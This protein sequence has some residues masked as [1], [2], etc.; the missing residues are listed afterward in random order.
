MEEQAQEY[1][2]ETQCGFFCEPIELKIVQGKNVYHGY[3]DAPKEFATVYT[4]KGAAITAISKFEIQKNVIGIVPIHA[5][6]RPRARQIPANQ[7]SRVLPW[8]EGS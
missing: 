1:I 4:T 8:G 3:V 6:R 7:K 2:I 5:E